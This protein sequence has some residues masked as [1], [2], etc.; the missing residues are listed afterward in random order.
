MTASF[1]LA[2]EETSLNPSVDSYAMT[3][4][5]PDDLASAQHLIKHISIR[6]IERHLRG[7][8]PVGRSAPMCLRVHDRGYIEAVCSRVRVRLHRDDRALSWKKHLPIVR[9]LPNYFALSDPN[10][11]GDERDYSGRSEE[12]EWIARGPLILADRSWLQGRA[13]EVRLL[14]RNCRLPDAEKPPHILCVEGKWLPKK[15]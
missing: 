7:I 6:K 10:P 13:H 15:S 1:V 8:D 9:S 12:G 4:R 2:W 14:L 5:D 11:H 3:T